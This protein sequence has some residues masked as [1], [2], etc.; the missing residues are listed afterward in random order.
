MSTCCDATIALVLSS[1]ADER[2][3]CGEHYRWSGALPDARVDVAD[4]AALRPSLAPPV[5]RLTRVEDAEL[6]RVRRLLTELR[7]DKGGPLGWAADGQAPAALGSNWTPALRVQTSVEVPAILP[8][9]FAAQAPESRAPRLDP[10]T[11]LGWLQRAGTLCQGLRGLYALCAEVR[12][13]ADVRARWAALPAR[14]RLAGVVVYGRKLVLA[15]MA[16][17]WRE[18]PV[19]DPEAL[20]SAQWA[21]VAG[22][23]ARQTER[24]STATGEALARVRGLLT[25][26]PVS[27]SNAAIGTP[28]PT[29]DVRPAPVDPASAR[30]VTSTA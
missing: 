10:D 25:P 14:E 3:R 17:W 9:A 21:E 1:R 24:A 16:E 8:G 26:P 22:I 13:P 5:A 28:L 23:V 12:A 2:C 7:P 11:T 20:R 19:V 27:A 4:E 30:P 15:A 6:V 18:P 29:V